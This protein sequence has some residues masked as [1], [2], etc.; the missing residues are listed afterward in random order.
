M[1]ETIRLIRERASLRKFQER[2][3]SQEDRDL[4]IEAALR[5]PTAGNLML[6]SII[7][8]DDQEKKDI[9]SKTCDNQPFIARAPL[10]MVFL[11][12]YQRWYDYFIAS[13]VE[14]Y[15]QQQG[16]DFT[17][18]TE[19]DLMLSCSDALI[20]AQNAVVGAES[21]G[22]GS[23][24]IGDIMEN[25]ETHR[26]L[27]TLPPWTFPVAM[28]VMGYYPP[29]RPMIKSRFDR[30]YIVHQ[31]SYHRLDQLELKTMLA[32]RAKGFNRANTFNAVNYGQYIYAR[33]TGADFSREMA[34]SVREMM[35]NWHGE[36]L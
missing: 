28:L 33:K 11:A 10:L 7:I 35:K 29:K 9:L 26:D 16:K 19:G 23:C 14:E 5:A 30:R 6:Y 34:R 4:I 25:Y 31:N 8:V 3:I 2:D 17:G 12:D 13:G 15:C 36:K 18:P 20:A 24:Y 21:L 22:I 32:E 1:N 27:L